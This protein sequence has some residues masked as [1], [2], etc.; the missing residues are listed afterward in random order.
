MSAH[1]VVAVIV[2]AVL[3]VGFLVVGGLVFAAYFFSSRV[4]VTRTGTHGEDETV[5][6]ETPFGRV[7]V[8][9]NREVDPATLDIPVYPEAKVVHGGHNA[10]VELDLDFADKALRIMAIE[11]ETTDPF[12]KVVAFYRQAAP[13]FS[14]SEK[15]GGK[16]ELLLQRGG[17]KKVI[18]IVRRQDMTRIA[19]ANIGE[20]EGN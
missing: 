20:P 18:G 12:D 10:R 7:R 9:K 2:G 1:R 4:H 5:R 11:M 13:D 17:Q 15:A 14:F 8:D 6:V 16:V 19:L 3:V